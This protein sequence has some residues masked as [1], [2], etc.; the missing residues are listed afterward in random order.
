[1]KASELRAKSAPELKELAEGLIRER[2]NLQMQKAMG[3]LAKPDRIRQVR[4]D[5]A[6]INLVLA[7]KESSR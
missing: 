1:M 7:E 6:R 4:S 2:F 5:V 3:Q